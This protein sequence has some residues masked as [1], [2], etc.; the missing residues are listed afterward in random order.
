MLRGVTVWIVLFE[1]ALLDGVWTCLALRSILMRF[2]WLPAHAQNKWE[3]LEHQPFDPTEQDDSSCWR[4]QSD[5]QLWCWIITN[6]ETCFVRNYF[7][8]TWWNPSFVCSRI[9]GKDAQALLEIKVADLNAY[10]AF[11]LDVCSNDDLIQTKR[12]G[13]NRISFISSV[14]FMNMWDILGLWANPNHQPSDF[15]A[16]IKQYN[17]GLLRSTGGG[18]PRKVIYTY[19]YIYIWILG[20]LSQRVWHWASRLNRKWTPP[21]EGWYW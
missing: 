5:L 1:L 20:Q 16:I 11:Y 2:F 10:R 3:R 19:I 4:K 6:V 15:R 7:L 14:C 13:W 17:T 21:S 9:T 8:T 12:K 18:Y